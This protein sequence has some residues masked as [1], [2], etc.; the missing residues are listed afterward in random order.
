M[1]GNRSVVG[2]R[3]RSVRAIRVPSICLLALGVLAVVGVGP[4]AVPAAA[5]C[6]GP[7]IR[8]DVGPVERGGVL[9][10]EGTGFGDSCYDTGPPPEGQGVL[11][12]PR[13]GIEVFVVQGGDE[14]LV[15]EGAADAD[16][17]FSVE[18]VVPPDLAPGEADVVVRLPDGFEPFDAEALPFTVSDAPPPAETETEVVAFGPGGASGV[19]PEVLQV[20]GEGDGEGGE[21]GQVTG[22]GGEGDPSLVPLVVSGAVVVVVAAVLL[23]LRARRRPVGPDEP[24]D[25]G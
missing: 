19:E 13:G 3:R 1:S 17:E 21:G 18:V 4:S 2:R 11:G 14:R 9:V 20:P 22:R 7:S 23:V 8:H 24:V 6:V 16:Y 15:A 5:D 10:V 25:T 12:K